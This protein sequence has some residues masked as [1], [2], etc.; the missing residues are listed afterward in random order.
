MSGT[1]GIGSDALALVCETVSA[2]SLTG[3]KTG[4]GIGCCNP[5]DD[6]VILSDSVNN[7]TGGLSGNRC[8]D[9]NGKSGRS[10]EAELT[11]KSSK[12]GCDG[13]DSGSCWVCSEMSVDCR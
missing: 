13:R 5:T 12:N 11:C 8:G 4:R 6:G 2:V 7:P 1:I 3:A 10:R 9:G